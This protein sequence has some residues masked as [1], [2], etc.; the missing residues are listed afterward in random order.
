MAVDEDEVSQLK[1]NADNLAKCLHALLERIEQLERRKSSSPQRQESTDSRA[2][3]YAEVA[4][5]SGKKKR[6]K[7]KGKHVDEKAANGGYV[8][9]AKIEL[10]EPENSEQVVMSDTICV[11]PETG[12]KKRTIV[13]ERVLTTKTFHAL[14]LDGAP[15]LMPS[16]GRQLGPVY[17]PR[18][19]QVEAAQLKQIEVESIFG[20]LVVVK[21]HPDAT[22]N[23]RP[24]DSI[25]EIDGNPVTNLKDIE[26]LRGHSTLTLTTSAIYRGPSIFYKINGEYS[27]EKDEKRICQWLPIEVKRGDVARKVNDLTHVGYLPTNLA[28]EKVSMLCPFGRRVLV[29]LGAPGVGRRTLKSMLLRSSPAHFATV[30]PM[31]SRAPRSSEQEGREYHFARKEDMLKRIRDGDMIEW[32]ELDTHLYGTSA[33]SVRNIVRGGRLCVLDCAP[34]ALSYLYNGEFMP[35]VVHIVPP[36]LDEFVQL[37]T[38]RQTRRTTEQLAQTCQESENI[39]SGTNAT[40]IHLTLVN[41]NMDVTFKRLLD[42]LEALRSETQVVPDSWMC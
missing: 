26:N 18:S 13:T 39:A 9:V 21:V 11:D 40:Q 42:N 12:L 22:H 16:N 31:T 1:S 30:I 37:E 14:T 27:S 3:S 5:T 24:G 32:G 25:T 35:F 20:Q 8:D 29:L 15:V 23:I 7:K 10:D 4:A 38:L 2:E 17:Q 19:V 41:R 33:E 28:M 34:R 36:Q 6:G